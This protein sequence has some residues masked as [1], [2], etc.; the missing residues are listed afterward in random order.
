MI[1]PIIVVLTVSLLTACARQPEPYAEFEARV[2]ALLGG[3][4]DESQTVP[5]AAIAVWRDGEIIWSHAAGAA[6]FEDDGQTLQRPLTPSSPVRVASIS[7]LATALTALSL[8]ED[9]RVDMDADVTD[10]LGFDLP[11]QPGGAPV[12]L[13]SLLSHTSGICEPDVYW[14]VEGDRLEDL[15]TDAATCPYPPGKGWTYANINYGIAAQVLENASGERFDRLATARVLAP[16]GLDAGFNWSGV[17]MSTRQSGATLHRRFDGVW[18]PQVDD[19]ETLADSRAS[20]LRRDADETG[21]D[22]PGG[23]PQEFDNGT[24]YSP[25]GG[26]RASVEDLA[27]LATAFLPNGIGAALGEPVWTGD[28]TPGVRAYAPGPQVLLPGQIES[29]PEL[30]LVG[31]IGEAYGFYGGAW[32]IIDHGASVA[33]FVTGVDC[34]ADISRDPVSGLSRY[35]AELMSIALGVL[36]ADEVAD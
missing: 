4:R 7:K 22:S 8:A 16:M 2:D 18:V 10:V 26:L 17:S 14:A 28:E 12:T 35:E 11:V 29:H 15:L 36:E 21:G 34:A 3:N 32:G 23:E 6:T 33:Y 24:L 9:G 25:Q 31:H 1:R 13:T 30:R 20:I 5:G 19:L 27:V